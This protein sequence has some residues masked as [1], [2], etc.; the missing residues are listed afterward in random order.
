MRA[1]PILFPGLILSGLILAQAAASKSTAA[2]KSTTPAKSATAAKST[3]AASGA[4]MTDE[5][6]TIYAIGVFLYKRDNLAGF[7]LSPAELELV[8]KGISDAAAGRPAVNLDVEGPKLQPLLDAR[9]KTAGAAYLAKA[10]TQAGFIKTPSGLLFKEERAGAGPSPK[11]T[12]T[13]Q[14]N[15]RGT[16]INGTE[17]D[18]SYKTGKPVA[19]PLTGV[20]PCWTEALQKMKVGGKAS[21]VCPY[22]I[23]YGETG[24]GTIPGFSTL[25][26]DVELVAINPPGAG[27]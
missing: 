24:R 11:P 15:Y 10:A 12:D 14:V 21:L 22:Q 25:L 9:T 2:A 1:L 19:L 17:F 8:K 13:V 20:I 26:F 23:A 5:Q 18:S 3:A 7:N 16:F 4:G 27:K 6:K